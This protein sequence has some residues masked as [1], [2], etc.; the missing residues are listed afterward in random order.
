MLSVNSY[1]AESLKMYITSGNKFDFY[2]LH[3]R[4]EVEVVFFD[5]TR[6][7]AFAAINDV[8]NAIN[9]ESCMKVTRDSDKTLET[10]KSN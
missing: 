1:F 10:I 3:A 9:M 7:K 6:T 4:H 5:S 8:E 2:Q